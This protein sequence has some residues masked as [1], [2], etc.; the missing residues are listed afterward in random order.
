MKHVR[1]PLASSDYISKN[2]IDEPLIK[3]NPICKDF[4]I[5][6]LNFHIIMKLRHFN[7]P[8]SVRYSPRQTGIK[9][10]LAMSSRCG[11]CYTS[12]YDPTTKLLHK[13]KKLKMAYEVCALALIKNHLVFALSSQDINLRTVKMLDLCLRPLQ[14]KPNVDML[15]DRN[16]FGVGVIDDR[17]Y[18]VGGII[19]LTALNTAEVFDVSVQEWQLISSMCTE[20]MG[21]GVGVLDNLLYAVG[22]FKCPFS[23]KSVECYDPSL[24]IW[25]PVAQMSTSR[26]RLGIGILDGVMY[27]IGGICQEH[28]NSVYLKSVEAYTPIANLW[29]PIADMHLSRYDPRVVTFNGL[30]YVM[31][32]SDG[33]S[34]LG[35]LEIYDPNTNTWTMEP[36]PTSGD[37]IHGAVIIDMPSH[38][39]SY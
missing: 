15:V 28:A 8:R 13:I 18:A 25:S 27:A 21:P 14:W 17:I 16:I 20:R 3:N 11:N 23:L 6:A 38:L 37:E 24:D 33:S 39:R 36:L 12:W 1:L 32:G 26:R 2:I 29:S 7:M 9:F 4:V 5:E 35:S 31:G 34:Q 22:G 30:L 10:L 19:D